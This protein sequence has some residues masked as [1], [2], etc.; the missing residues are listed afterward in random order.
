MAVM[1]K[2]TYWRAG[3]KAHEIAVADLCRE[4][5]EHLAGRDFQVVFVYPTTVD[6][7]TGYPVRTG[8]VIVRVEILP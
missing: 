8:E 2:D 4:L 3:T 6:A 7:A 1:P 5:T